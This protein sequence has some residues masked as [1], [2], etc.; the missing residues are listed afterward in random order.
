MDKKGRQGD[1]FL[2]SRM[3]RISSILLELNL[4]K[5]LHSTFAP[6][7]LRNAKNSIFLR[8]T[9]RSPLID[10]SSV[11]ALGR[12]HFGVDMW[13][14]RTYFRQAWQRM[15]TMI[16]CESSVSRGA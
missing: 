12:F 13:F 5:F 1:A 6:H 9:D 7:R 10:Q 2:V 14:S 8:R 4:E 3:I 11:W 16:G 15:M